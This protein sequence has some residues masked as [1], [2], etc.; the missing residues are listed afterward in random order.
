MAEFPRELEQALVRLRAAVAEKNFA[1]A[2]AL[3]NFSREPA[4]RFGEI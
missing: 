1:R 4:L 2:E 3:Y